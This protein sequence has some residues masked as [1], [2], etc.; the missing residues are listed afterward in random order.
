MSTV[1]S[2]AYSGGLSVETLESILL[3]LCHS[4]IC[5]P[6]YGGVTKST[7]PTAL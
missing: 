6:A 1:Q 5:D 4:R 7:V 3:E 2:T